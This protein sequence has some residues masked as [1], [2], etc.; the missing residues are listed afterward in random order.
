MRQPRP[1]PRLVQPPLAVTRTSSV[2]P[3][4]ESPSTDSHAAQFASDQ[5]P[6][7]AGWAVPQS[8]VE[9]RRETVL[10]PHSSPLPAESLTTPP[11]VSSAH[12]GRGD[13]PIPRS[14][15]WAPLPVRAVAQLQEGARRQSDMFTVGDSTTPLAP[16]IRV[17]IGRVEVRAIMPPAAPAPRPKAARP[18]PGLSLEE[19]L[20]PGRR[21]QQ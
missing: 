18:G 6:D 1:T 4:D 21:G 17:S 5:R 2:Q 3:M 20:K 16:V 12:I 15:P 7:H 10:E 19:Y 11:D 13:D 14:T 8:G 9:A